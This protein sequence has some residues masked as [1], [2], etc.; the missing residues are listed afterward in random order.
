MAALT[1]SST[2][3]CRFLLAKKGEVADGEDG[4]YGHLSRISKNLFLVTCPGNANESPGIT[5][6]C[7]VLAVSNC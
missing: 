2:D 5:P 7:L 4:L 1:E 3:S 6:S